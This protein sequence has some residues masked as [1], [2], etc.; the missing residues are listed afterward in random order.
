[1]SADNSL[2]HVFR[3]SPQRVATNVRLSDTMLY[4]VLGDGREIGAPLARFPWLA[5]AQ[6]QQR[7]NW[8]IEPRGFAVYWDDL[9]DGIEVDHLLE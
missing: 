4:I 3:A 5:N 6:P 2:M 7:A 1:M 9:D 8:H